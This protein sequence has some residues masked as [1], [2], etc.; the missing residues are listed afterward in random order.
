MSRP[1]VNKLGLSVLTLFI[2]LVLVFVLLRVV[3]NNPAEI[4]LGDA[5]TPETV[6]QITRLWGLDKPI[7]EQFVIY[8]INLLRGDAGISF[9]YSTPG[10]PIGI[11]VWEIVMGRL[12]YTIALALS[13]LALSVV[14]AVPLGVLSA[15]KADSVLDH[16]IATGGIVI[17]S[18]PHF[19]LALILIEIVSVQLHL[20][21]SGGAT[22]PLSIILPSIMLSIS[23]TVLLTRVTRTEV[24]RIMA[25]DY[26][27]TARAKGLSERT[28]LWRHALPNALI[29]L[30][31]L[32][33]LRL[34]GLLNG[35]VVMEAIFRWP[36]VGSLMLNSIGTRDYPTIQ[37]LVPL[38]A[39]AFIVLNFLTDVIYELVDP[40]LRKAG[41]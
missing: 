35:A 33:G 30:I 6:A 31:T 38:T 3:P 36:G 29:P 2:T 24:L 4:M 22:S 9:Q 15:S 12:P 20:L 25:S 28:V 10:A 7:P 11:T 18:I 14:V 41:K 13:S 27:R 37:F 17:N 19:W 40:R 1:L 5:A 16:S 32:I 34:G 23:F 8:L 21:P 39:F 26:V